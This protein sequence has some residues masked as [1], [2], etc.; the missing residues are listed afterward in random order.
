MPISTRRILLALPFILILA[1]FMPRPVSA[2]SM[3]ARPGDMAFGDAGAPVTMV[4]YYS[5]NC[6][7]CAVFH[8]QMFAALKA[9]YIDSGRV[10]FVFRD[11]PLNWAALEAAILTHCAGPE[12]FLAVQQA[13]FDSFRRWSGAQSTLLA[14]AEVGEAVGVTRA[15]FKRCIEAGELEKQVIESYEFARRELGVE[16]TPTFFINGE[17]H[18]GGISLKRLAEI[19]EGAE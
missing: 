6:P 19:L 10:R 1:A 13:L 15:E 5:L 18:V 4:E 14:V 3:E 2:G 9:E 7:H 8:K 17:K 11:F 16:G 12:R